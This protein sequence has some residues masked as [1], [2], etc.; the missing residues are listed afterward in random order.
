MLLVNVFSLKPSLLKLSHN[1]Q[2][3]CFCIGDICKNLLILS[4]S[5]SNVISLDPPIKV[6]LFQLIILSAKSIE[7]SSK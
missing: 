2:N 3:T 1:I 4:K 7:F 6:K 5:H